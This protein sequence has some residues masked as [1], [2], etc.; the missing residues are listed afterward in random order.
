MDDNPTQEAPSQ[1]GLQLQDLISV[2]QLIQLSTSRGAFKAE[3]LSAVGG[4]YDRLLAFLKSSGA[5]K[6]VEKEEAP[7]EDQPQE[8]ANA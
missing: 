1:T 5:I 8:T 6:E 4:L 7:K 2:V 3:E